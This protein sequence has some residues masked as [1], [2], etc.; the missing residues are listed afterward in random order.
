MKEIVARTKDGL[1][2]AIKQG[3][4]LGRPNGS[5]D[6]G[7]RRRSGYLRRWSE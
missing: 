1:K 6:K 2:R 4:K 5:K 3:K 7:R